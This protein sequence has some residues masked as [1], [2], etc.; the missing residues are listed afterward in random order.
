MHIIDRDY[1]HIHIEN[2]HKK[3]HTKFQL[4]LLDINEDIIEIPEVSMS[5]MTTIPAV[6][7]QRICRD[8]NNIGNNIEVIRSKNAFTIRCMG[9]FA[10]QETVIESDESFEGEDIKGIYSLRYMNMFTKAVAMCSTV[11]ILQEHDNRFL[12]LKYHVA[13]LGFLNFYLATK[14]EE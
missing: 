7:F 12:I 2:S 4:K 8:M 5:V 6:D 13:N 10:N 1:I 9:D 14:V 11:Q 3:T